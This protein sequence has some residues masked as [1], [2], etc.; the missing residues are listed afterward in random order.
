MTN[1]V[2]PDQT[3]PDGAVCIVCICHFV[4]NFGLR[5][6]LTFTSDLVIPGLV[7]NG[8]AKICCL[9]LILVLFYSIMVIKNDFG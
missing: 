6:F 2:D 5:N 4:P 3:A 9:G 7:T 8:T 1:N